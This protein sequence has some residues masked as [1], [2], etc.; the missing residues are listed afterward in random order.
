M[1]EPGFWWRKPGLA[2]GLL[3]PA[4]SLLRRDR[5]AAYGASGRARRRAGHLRRKLHARRRRQDADRDH[6]RED[7]AATRASGV[8]CLSR[9]Y[10][11]SVAGPK[12]RRC[13]CRHGRAGRRRG[14]AAG[15]RGADRGGA[16]P[17]RRRASGAGGG[18]ASVIV[19]DDGLQNAS[20]AKDFTIAVIDAR[21]GI[22][23]RSR[24][25]RRAS[26]RA[27]RGA[28]RAHRRACWWS[29]TATARARSIAAAPHL[30][31][32]H[33]RLA[34][35]AAAVAALHGA[36]RAGLRRHRRSGQVF[37]HRGGGRHRD[38]RAPRLSRSSPLHRRGG[39]ANWSCR[40]STA[41]WRCSPP[42]RIARAW[43]ASRR[44]PRCAEKSHVLPVTMVVAEADALRKLVL[45]KLRR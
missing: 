26:A 11:G 4:A 41:G 23:N 1:R 40:P 6:A 37:R 21:R 30:P 35:D 43:R 24:V 34:P 36:Q 42:R 12:L 16:R 9:G 25:S 32:F 19:M 22:G 31:V 33:G 28:A 15:A 44:S 7:A 3:A 13:A 18:R 17:R 45:A 14:A 2:A 27:A 5:R 29:A 20:L 38:R 8:F 10:G 39:R